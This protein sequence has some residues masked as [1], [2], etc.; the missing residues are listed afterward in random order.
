MKRINIKDYQTYMGILIDIQDPISYKEFHHPAS[1]NINGDKLLLEHK[2]LL[3]K[4][5]KYYIVCRKG[6]K[7][8]KVANMLEFYGYDV[9]QVSY[10]K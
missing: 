8:R 5:N 3:N 1:I 10:D 9:V 2:V 7:S 6:Q 4:K